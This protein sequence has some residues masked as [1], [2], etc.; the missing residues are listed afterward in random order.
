MLVPFISWRRCSVHPG[1]G[2][3]APPAMQQTKQVEQLT[4]QHQV[5][6]RC[7]LGVCLER[8]WRAHLKG[9]LCPAITVCAH[10]A[11]NRYYPRRE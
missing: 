4:G 6:E 3:M 7:G 1:T 2:A 8:L 5:G 11:A 10:I 9:V